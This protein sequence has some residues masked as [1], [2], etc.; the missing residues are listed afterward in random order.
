M[1]FLKLLIDDLVYCMYKGSSCDKQ[2]T[3]AYKIINQISD[4]FTS[5][6]LTQN[7]LSLKLKESL[8]M[9]VA[10]YII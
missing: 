1:S 8:F 10:L 2:Y 5:L 6:V 9:N 3:Y 7:I 4:G